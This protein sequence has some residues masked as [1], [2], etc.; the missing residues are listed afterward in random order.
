MKIAIKW[1]AILSCLFFAQPGLTA[2]K[3][4]LAKIQNAYNQIES[5][6]AEFDQTLVHKESGS[7]EKRKGKIAFQKPLLVR[8]QTARPHEETLVVNR[9]EIW[10]YIPDEEIAY[11]YSPAA[12]QDSRSIIQVITGQARLDKD[13]DIKP[14]GKANGMEKLLLYPRN[15]SPQMVEALIWVDPLSGAIQRAQVKDFYGNSNEIAFRT[16]KPGQ[17]IAA[18]QFRFK[19]P[20]GVEVEDRREGGTPQKQLFY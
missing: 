20:K 8:W 14:A 2:D 12:A 1:M 15:P 18:S 10:D 19:P 9:E 5:F 4:L 7:T 6:E 11:R 3:T 16:F 17:K 13:F